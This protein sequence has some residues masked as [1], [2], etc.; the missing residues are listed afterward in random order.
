MPNRPQLPAYLATMPAHT[1]LSLRDMSQI[2]GVSENAVA[3]RV[4][5]GALPL[6]E[7]H[8][9]RRARRKIPMW[10]LGTIKKIIRGK[11]RECASK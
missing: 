8:V 10:R 7:V 4:E 1:L 3:S 9:S 5:T 11:D 6:P 2:F